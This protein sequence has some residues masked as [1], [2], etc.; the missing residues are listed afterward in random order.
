METYSP[1]QIAAAIDY[2]EREERKFFRDSVDFR[3]Y[4]TARKLALSGMFAPHDVTGEWREGGRCAKRYW[5][6]ATDQK[7]SLCMVYPALH[8][9]PNEGKLIADVVRSCDYA[10]KKVTE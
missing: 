8:G 3:D 7:D 2:T 6:V 5:A 9:S 10:W 4:A 1:Q